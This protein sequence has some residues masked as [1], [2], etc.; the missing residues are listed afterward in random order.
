MYHLL[1]ISNSSGAGRG[2]QFSVWHPM[3]QA[4][5]L[6]YTEHQKERAKSEANKKSD[7]L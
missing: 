4:S 3:S 7:V 2:A 6:H 1:E 5:L